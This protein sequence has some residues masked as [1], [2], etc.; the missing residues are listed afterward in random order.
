MITRYFK[1]AGL[2]FG[3]TMPEDEPLW[4][5]MKQYQPFLVEGVE[6]DDTL[7][8]TARL[9]DSISL[10]NTKLL[11]TEKPEEGMPPIAIH[12]S[13]DAWYIDSVSVIKFGR[14]SKEAC[15]AFNHKNHLYCINNALMMLYAFTSAPY[16]AV[17]MHAS[18][19][20]NSGKAFLFLAKSG[21]GKST[22]SSMWLKAVPGSELMNDD[23]P[24]VRIDDSGVAIAYG[25]PWSGKTPC[26]RNVQAPVGAFVK[27]QRAPYNK[28]TKLD[29]LQSFA[30][31]YSSASANRTDDDA[32]EYLSETISGLLNS[33]P[34][35]CLECLPNEDAALECYGVV[36]KK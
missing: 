1:V 10:E 15:F 11:Y 3:V 31:V 24:I 17:E 6:E 2:V 26:Y 36:M 30:I 35:Y 16:K 20:K 22:Q 9:V 4:N 32:C 12:S 27:I 25:S 5:N 8:F 7:I 33:A 13:E 14:N 19:I 23:N 21:T 29:V 34:C 18:V 28:C